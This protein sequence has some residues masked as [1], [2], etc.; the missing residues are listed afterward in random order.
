MFGY[1]GGHLEKKFSK[2]SKI[3]IIIMVS[4]CTLLYELG[5]Y[6]LNIAI[7]GVDLE[8][9]SF[10]KIN[11]I[12]IIYNLILTI[13]FYPLIKKGGYYIQDVYKGNK[14]LTRYF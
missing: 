5:V 2:D 6:I 8:M 13:I 14:I 7:N 10:L 1:I 12:E 11:I 9:A 4:S 3:T